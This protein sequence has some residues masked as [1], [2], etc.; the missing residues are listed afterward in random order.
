MSLLFDRYDSAALMRLLEEVGVLES[1]RAKGFGEL[2]LSIDSTGLALPHIALRANKAGRTHLLLETCLRRVSVA[3]DVACD[4]GPG[5]DGRLDLVLVHWVREQDPTADFTLGRPPLLLQDHPGLG[6][7]RRAFR[8]AVRIGADLGVDGVASLPKFFHDAVIFHRSRLF[9][10][11]DGTE[12]GR[13]EALERDLG[14]LKLRDATVAVA[15]W[16]VRGQCDRV[17]R[18][19]PGYQAFPLSAR[20]TAHFH[21]PDYAAAVA[22]ARDGHRFQVDAAALAA[23]C[24]QI[25]PVP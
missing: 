22:A 10:F 24:T 3:A 2:A 9:L 4:G 14:A 20:L 13:F 8:V 7:L 1:L 5:G 12:Q 21:S 23:A 25:G 6:V 19:Q 17:V 11:L 16:C 15:A 18:W